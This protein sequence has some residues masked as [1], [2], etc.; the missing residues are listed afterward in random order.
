MYYLNMRITKFVQIK[1]IAFPP[2][3]E[4]YKEVCNLSLKKK[5]TVNVGAHL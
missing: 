5:L 4:S 2:P 3:Q 1:L